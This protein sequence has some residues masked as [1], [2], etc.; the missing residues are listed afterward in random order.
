MAKQ[1]KKEL[2]REEKIAAWREKEIEKH[3]EHV[4]ISKANRILKTED[5]VP[6]GIPSLDWTLVVGGIA[7][8]RVYIFYGDPSSGKTALSLH[9][10]AQYQKQGLYVMFID[11]ENTFETEFAKVFGVDVE[12]DTF[13]EVV[14]PETTEQTFEIITSAVRAGVVDLIVVDSVPALR[15]KDMVEGNR[16]PDNMT[17]MFKAGVFGRN[18][19]MLIPEMAKARASVIFINHTYETN[20]PFAQY[21]EAPTKGGNTLKYNCDVRLQ[22]HAKGMLKN[23]L[24]QDIGTKVVYKVWKNKLGINHRLSNQVRLNWL[25]GFMI[26]D[27]VIKTAVDLD[28]IQIAGAWYYASDK[29]KGLFEKMKIVLVDPNPPKE[30]ASDEDKQKLEGEAKKQV[31]SKKVDEVETVGSTDPLVEKDDKIKVEE[32]GVEFRAQGM[33]NLLALIK[34]NPQVIKP[35]KKLVYDEIALDRFLSEE[36]AEVDEEKTEK[37]KDKKDKKGD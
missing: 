27:N 17:A 9:I 18:L 10:M 22:I 8:G 7:R 33:A 32:K 11:A 13:F 28:V 16:K 19:E 21:K 3:G 1:E 29:L 20:D 24:D 34:A 6:T 26:N 35:I 36:N 4:M 2:T 25:K 31:K 5:V 12:A 15:P 30:S 14:K 23:K 37:K